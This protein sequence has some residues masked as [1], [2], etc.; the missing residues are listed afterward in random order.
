MQPETTTV[1]QRLAAR[2]QELRAATDARA[3]AISA[4][5]KLPR[6][7]CNLMRLLLEVPMVTHEMFVSPLRLLNPKQTVIRLRKRLDK[8]E[9]PIHSTRGI[10]YWFDDETKARLN[11]MVAATEA[12]NNSI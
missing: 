12:K 1:E 2:A 5:F 3:L 7:L 11:D 10:G 4:T 6:Q 8:F 9:A